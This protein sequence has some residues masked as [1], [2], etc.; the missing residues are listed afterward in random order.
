MVHQPHSPSIA[1]CISSRPV[2]MT[3]LFQIHPTAMLGH[4]ITTLILKSFI[5]ILKEPNQNPLNCLCHFANTHPHNLQLQRSLLLLLPQ[6]R[7]NRHRVACRN[8]LEEMIIPK[9]CRDMKTHQ[10]S[11]LSRH[12]QMDLLQI[13]P[14]IVAINF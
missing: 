13:C 6:L 2:R 4:A 9:V 1:L 14:H 3:W 11:I 10:K 12:M 8:P 7:R 5:P